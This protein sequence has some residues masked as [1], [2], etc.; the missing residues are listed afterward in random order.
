MPPVYLTRPATV[1]REPLMTI[2]ATCQSCQSVFHAMDEH[3]G[4]RARCPTCQEIIQLPA[5]GSSGMTQASPQR[6]ATP[7]PVPARRPDPGAS[8]AAQRQA[9]EHELLAAFETD[10]DR[11]RV[12]L[13]YR[14][15]ILL[16]ALVMLLLPVIYCGIIVLIGL[17][18]YGHATHNVSILSMGRGR[19]HLVTVAIYLAPIIV[20]TIVVLF[21]LKPLFAR[22]IR[23][24][25]T[26]TLT[27]QAEPLLFA[28]VERLCRAV[29]APQPA[30]IRVDFD[31]NASAAFDDGFL[32]LFR[33]Q[34]VL[35]IGVPLVA[36]LDVGQFAGV[37][38]HEFGHF[39]QGAGMRLTFVVR[40][41]SY[42][43]VRVVYERDAWDQW[44]D[45]SVEDADWRIAWILQSARLGVWL[46]RW[47]LWALMILGHAVSSFLLRQMEFH[48]DAH[49]ARLVGSDVFESTSFRLVSLAL[50]FEAVFRDL[51]ALAGQGGLP[52]DL[53]L[54]I[55][56]KHREL[57]AEA[58]ER[59]GHQIAIGKTGWLDT[60]PATNARIR[61]A[62]REGV[63]KV[64]ASQ[65]PA[66][67]LFSDFKSLARNTTCDYYRA[68]VGAHIHPSMLRSSE[69]LLAGEPAGP[70]G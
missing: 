30:R 49:E 63:E 52:D 5:G 25:R 40:R 23:T 67:V 14:V 22:P 59:I 35:T 32:R 6:S 64:F 15:A 61:R 48:A 55:L 28:F 44:L 54:L 11:V 16:S 66:A 17:A 46:S 69:E 57:P 19:G 51:R 38:A 31:I 58:G 56:A 43:L 37:L 9:L 33:R 41:I 18:V 3:A 13:M 42:W 10:I 12:P 53:A 29:G 65:R 20:G 36:G 45:E 50:A 7:Q 8:K 26:R 2:R 1:I 70:S 27:R 47:V 34:L 21:M 60:H 4:K 68:C 24:G 39:T 62:E